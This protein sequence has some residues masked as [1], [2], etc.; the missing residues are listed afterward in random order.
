MTTTVPQFEPE[1]PDSLTYRININ[2]DT[3]EFYLAAVKHY[4][5]VL[6]A[7]LKALESDPDLRAILGPTEQRRF[8]IDEQVDLAHRLREVLE[9]KKEENLNRFSYFLTLT[10]GVV[11]FIKS[12]ALLY[13]QH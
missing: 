2:G 6:N 4:E 7:D 8:P 1:P 5:A 12:A 10:H 9:R 3:F 11:R 13:H